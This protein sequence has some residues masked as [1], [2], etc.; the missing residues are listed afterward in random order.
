M[1]KPHV[2]LKNGYISDY[3]DLT[4]WIENTKEQAN[5]VVIKKY[6]NTTFTIQN[7]KIEKIAF[8]SA[9]AEDKDYNNICTT[10]LGNHDVAREFVT[11]KDTF[12]VGLSVDSNLIYTNEITY[13][14][15]YYC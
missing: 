1:N 7:A 5:A 8:K 2:T 12:Y 14:N 11:D 9:Y 10:M 4:I 13:D 15:C 3:H 6:K